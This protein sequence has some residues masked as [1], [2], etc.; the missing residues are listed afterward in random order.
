VDV[1]GR[2]YTF[3]P[4]LVGARHA[5]FGDFSIGNLWTD[6][7]E[8]LLTSRAL[9]LQF[10]DIEAGVKR[11]SANCAYFQWC[12]GGSPANKLFENGSLDSTETMF[13]RMTRQGVLE[14]TLSALEKWLE[15][16][17]RKR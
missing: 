3:S 4:E 10:D 9:R 1:E 13:C 16:R 2:A 6:D 5:R 14:E 15:P 12:G 17:V 11:C 7:L 8:K